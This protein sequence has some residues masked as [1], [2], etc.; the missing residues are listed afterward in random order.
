MEGQEAGKRMMSLSNADLSRVLHKSAIH[1]SQISITA[2]GSGWFNDYPD[3]LRQPSF[4]LPSFAGRSMPSRKIHPAPPIHES[5]EGMVSNL[6]K[7]S[8][9]FMADEDQL[10]AP[11]TSVNRP[12]STLSFS[13]HRSAS[14]GN[15]R[16]GS[17]LLAAL[18]PLSPSSEQD[19]EKAEA[20]KLADI[21]RE[22]LLM[23]LPSASTSNVNLMAKPSPHRDIRS[24]SFIVPS[25][26][27]MSMTKSFTSGGKPKGLAM[28]ETPNGGDESSASTPLPFASKSPRSAAVLRFD[29]STDEAK[30]GIQEDEGS[31]YHSPITLPGELQPINPSSAINSPPVKSPKVKSHQPDLLY[32][33][34][35]CNIESWIQDLGLASAWISERAMEI[36]SQQNLISSRIIHLEACM[37]VSASAQESR[38]PDCQPELPAAALDPLPDDPLL[39]P[40]A[41]ESA[42]SNDEE[43]YLD[44][45]SSDVLEGGEIPPQVE[46][47]VRGLGSDHQPLIRSPT[48]KTDLPSSVQPP[49]SPGEARA[50]DSFLARIVS[51]RGQRARPPDEKTQPKGS[52]PTPAT[53]A[54]TGPRFRF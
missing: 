18:S 32:S 37:Q 46:A 50:K 6:R 22:N 26:S 12:K 48:I 14:K 24:K 5:A 16:H 36:E 25:R 39:P 52:M 51:I 10:Q 7:K 47:A 40:A 34:A 8:V 13:I 53:V 54:P 41:L 44:E 28:S 3:G 2:N 35:L 19:I 33:S 21:V 23:R 30:D 17:S 45:K 31:S 15:L 1:N 4:A 38:N 27:P 42:A 49:E 43:A 20:I 11:A 29:L 9:M